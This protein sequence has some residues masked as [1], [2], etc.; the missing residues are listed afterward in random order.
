MDFCDCC[1]EV[2]ELKHCKETDMYHCEECQDEGKEYEDY[3][4]KGYVKVLDWPKQ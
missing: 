4:I 2:R 3:K 1:Q